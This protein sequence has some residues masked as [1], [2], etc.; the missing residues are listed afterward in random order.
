MPCRNVFIVGLVSD[1]VVAGP[2]VFI[3]F[4]VLGGFLNV[5]FGFLIGFLIVF[6]V[7]V[8]VFFV[9]VAVVFVLVVG[10][11]VVSFVVL[12]ILR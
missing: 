3:D 4:S 9:V 1:R 12:N 5:A 2:T 11:C 8:V 6:F 7:V 10:F